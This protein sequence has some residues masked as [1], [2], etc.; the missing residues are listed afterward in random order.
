MTE[1]VELRPS[2]PSRSRSD[3]MVVNGQELPVGVAA[4]IA[5]KRPF[6][7]RP[8]QARQGH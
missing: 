2:K 3:S 1:W 5:M 7:V 8:V 4:Q 6:E